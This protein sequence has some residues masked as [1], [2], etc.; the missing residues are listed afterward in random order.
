[1]PQQGAGFPPL[2]P[3]ATF[4]DSSRLQALIIEAAVFVVFT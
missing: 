2:P 1:M 4:L 3:Q